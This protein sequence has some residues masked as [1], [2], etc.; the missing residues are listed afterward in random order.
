MYL[1]QEQ[2]PRAERAKTAS[3]RLHGDCC[4]MTH[5]V[6]NVLRDARGKRERCLARF[7]TFS[8]GHAPRHIELQADINAWRKYQVILT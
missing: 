8:T 7:E 5:P 4:G 1:P 3:H 2:G 6:D